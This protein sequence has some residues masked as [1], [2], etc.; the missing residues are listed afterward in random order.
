MAHTKHQAEQEINWQV[1]RRALRQEHP[2]VMAAI[3]GEQTTIELLA[4]KQITA[5]SSVAR[6]AAIERRDHSILF[7]LGVQ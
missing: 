2:L 1:E 4:H 5:Y 7:V 3:E 6:Q